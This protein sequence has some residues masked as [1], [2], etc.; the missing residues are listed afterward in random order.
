MKIAI[1]GSGNGGCAAAADW[2][3][4]GFQV[5]LFDFDS[6]PDT[7]DAI[8]R[9]KGIQ[10]EGSFS[11]F[12][13]IDYAGHAIDKAVA[14]SQVIMMVG[15]SF[16]TKPFAEA[17]R[18]HVRE[19]H[20]II[21]C[22]GSCGGAFE[23]R[24]VLKEQVEKLNIVI[25]ET[26]T[27]PYACRITGPGQ[28]RIF[29]KL[30]GG[31]YIAALPASRTAETLSLFQQVYPTATAA[32]NIFHAMLQ[33]ANPI[34]HPAVTLLNTGLIERTQGD[35]NF[36]EDGVTPA[37]G[38][39]IEGLDN[40]RIALGKA[41]G[42]DILPDP[43]IGSIQGYMVRDDYQT[44][45]STAPGFKGIKAQ[46]S[47]DHRYINEDVG[48]GLVFMS[49]LGALFNVATPV[50]NSVITIASTIMGRDYRSEGARSLA[51]L[52]LPEVREELLALV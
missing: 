49:Q 46:K 47:L 13:P 34:I 2:A 31:L 1:L 51:S 33:N 7:I 25:A 19:N 43:Q 8:N 6:F 52:G 12:A 44:G 4:H 35:F 45:Y 11:G 17:I 26:A 18:P 22:P 32:K 27:L 5:T 16:S 36:Y 28:V 10:V 3:L 24:N 48:Y 40:E 38:N 37:V 9:Q 30:V 14:D 23:V 29:L 15:P 39:L 42:V 21:V 50:T 20:L 41:I